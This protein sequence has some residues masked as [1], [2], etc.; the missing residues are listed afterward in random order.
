MPSV[1]GCGTGRSLPVPVLSVRRKQNRAKCSGT[2]VI[3]YRVIA[4]CL[5]PDGSGLRYTAYGDVEL[6]GTG[7]WSTYYPCRSPRNVQGDP[8][9]AD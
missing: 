2:K 5:R 7:Y 8:L 4:S 6:I 3:G 1:Y 9:I